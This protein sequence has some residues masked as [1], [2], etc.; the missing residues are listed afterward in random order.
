MSEKKFG[1][2]DAGSSLENSG[3]GLWR[4]RVNCVG[5][6]GN[7]P[8]RAGWCRTHALRVRGAGPSAPPR[9]ILR[10]CRPP[11][12]GPLSHTVSPAGLGVR[13]ALGGVPRCLPGPGR[14][15]F[16]LR[17]AAGW[18]WPTCVWWQLQTCPGAVPRGLCGWR[19]GAWSWTPWAR[20]LLAAP[21]APGLAP[22]PRCGAA[23]SSPLTA[24]SSGKEGAVGALLQAS[25]TREGPHGAGRQGPPRSRT[26]RPEGPARTSSPGQ[27]LAGGGQSAGFPASGLSRQGESLYSGTSPQR[28]PQVSCVSPCPSALSLSPLSNPVWHPWDGA[29]TAG[30]PLSDPPGPTAR[31]P[32]PLRSASENVP[33]SYVTPQTLFHKLSS[34][35]GPRQRS[36]AQPSPCSAPWARKQSVCLRREP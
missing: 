35:L 25:R 4:R 22:W 6:D 21:L 3:R 31:R 24:Q 19:P 17:A 26:Q 1:G 13:D 27:A 2:R 32:S 30:D 29:V 34:F 15:L 11:E 20:V 23:T 12:V 18:A 28:S 36:T 33:W 5:S 8:G 7:T 16:R 9:R 14:M 10:A